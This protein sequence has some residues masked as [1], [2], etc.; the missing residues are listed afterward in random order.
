VP[1]A[2]LRTQAVVAWLRGGG[3]SA[4]AR[5]VSV[6]VAVLSVG[7]I[8]AAF[9]WPEPAAPGAPV[10]SW[11]V[12]PAG[13][14]HVLRIPST[15][16]EA[17]VVPIDV[18]NDVLNP[19]EDFRTVGWWSGSAIPGTSMGQTVITGHTVHS[20]GG[21]MDLV[22]NLKP[23]DEVDIVTAKG[24][25]RYSVLYSRVFSRA[26]V[27]RRAATMFGQDFGAGQLVLVTCTDFNGV[28]YEENIVVFA[29]PIQTV[30]NK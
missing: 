25:V 17:Y 3:L 2:Q 8:L 10:S 11:A 7:L 21:V 19:P 15:Q 20:G 26:E 12:M 29:T 23:N 6:F 5:S 24:T 4:V 30:S 13:A 22:P 27:A 9:I 1:D 14:P 28:D 16:A 18:R